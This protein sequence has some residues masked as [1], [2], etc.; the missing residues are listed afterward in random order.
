MSQA[1]LV[2]VRW[3]HC[4]MALKG[5][6]ALYSHNRVYL[7]P[8]KQESIPRIIQTPTLGEFSSRYPPGWI[9]VKFVHI[10]AHT[11]PREAKPD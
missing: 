10:Y 6:L 3:K 8:E 1:E 11:N 5:L 2:R 9:A 4:L 7:A